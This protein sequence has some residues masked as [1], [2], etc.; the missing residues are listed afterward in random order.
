MKLQMEW[1]RNL[2]RLLL[3]WMKLQVEW[4]RTPKRLLLKLHRKQVKWLRTPKILRM[5]QMVVWRL[6]TGHFL[7]RVIQRRRLQTMSLSLRWE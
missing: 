3:R 2:K 6:G 7:F 4:L 1:L 5:K